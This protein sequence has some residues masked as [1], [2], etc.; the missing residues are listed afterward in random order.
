MRNQSTSH[1]SRPFQRSPRWLFNVRAPHLL[2]LVLVLIPTPA[3][4]VDK[5][6]TASTRTK[7]NSSY[8]FTHRPAQAGAEAVQRVDY[9]L[10]L[11][12]TIKQNGQVVITMPRDVQRKEVRRLTILE[13]SHTGPTRAK[14]TF[15]IAQ[16]SIAMKG[17][18]Q[19]LEPQ[20]VMGKSYLVIRQGEELVITDLHGRAPPPDELAIVAASMQAIGQPNPIGT[21]FH[22]RSI[23]VGQSVR[24]PM[25]LASQL[26]G[27]SDSKALGADT[28]LE[29]VLTGADK[30]NGMRLANF[31]S[32]L[33]AKSR[34]VT[35]R[36][37][38][39][40]GTLVIEIDSC[41]V[42]SMAMIGAVAMSESHGRDQG[43]YTLRGSGQL[44]VS[45]NVNHIRR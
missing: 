29:L 9:A 25:E 14:V 32:R 44:N 17:D 15:E 30:H 3:F 18:A 22:G 43:K 33:R 8:R 6:R 13:A 4:G 26:L 24:L 10:Q 7:S 38:D 11:R 19:R 21:F 12:T 31:K 2:I 27:L 16:Q 35:S 1:F 5:S 37:I 23:R 34:D 42:V 39:L 41:R 40:N 28:G 45:M 20:V 36:D